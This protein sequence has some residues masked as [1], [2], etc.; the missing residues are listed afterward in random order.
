MRTENIKLDSIR[1]DDQRFR[2][3]FHFDLTPLIHS[4]SET[5][6]I[7]PPVI[8][9]REGEV[10]IVTGW[11]RVL[12]CRSLDIPSIPCLVFEGQGDFEAFRLALQENLSF[13]PFTLLEKARI[14]DRLIQLGI[15][16]NAVVKDHLS[17]LEIPP[18]FDYLDAYLRIADLDADTQSIIHSKN[19]A[20]PVVRLLTE[21]S[22]EERRHL[23]SL[24]LP[25]GQNKQKELLQNL[26]EISRRDGVPVQ[27][28]LTCED[29]QRTVA[30]QN[31]SPFQKAE[32]IRHH[33][34]RQRY[35]ALS[36]WNDTFQSQKKD[37][38]WPEDIKI[39]PSPFF[40]GEEFTVHFTFKDFDDFKTKLTK[41][42]EMASDAK[43]SR[44]LRFS[45]K[46]KNE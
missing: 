32:A 6:L 44:I 14:L 1:F 2:I 22:E 27:K 3:S 5:G 18:T 28:I 34:Q 39:E 40:E 4:V 35:P 20:F 15:S 33:I 45:P 31:L 17:Y 21:Y 26:L 11:K 24:L 41:L 9:Y 25:L 8:T 19:M 38:E 12:A 23:L 29:I 7:H 36:A 10:L 16:E 13:R 46:K 42:N 30:N 43:I 37:L